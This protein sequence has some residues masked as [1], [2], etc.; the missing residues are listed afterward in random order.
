[1]KEKASSK[2]PFITHFPSDERNQRSMKISPVPSPANSVAAPTPQG[3]MVQKIRSLKMATNATPASSGPP[4]QEEV[5]EPGV[6]KL[7]I[8]ANN[9][10]TEA[11]TEATEP[12]SPQFAELARRRRA[13]QVKERELTDR[14]KALA[15]KSQG[16]DAVDLARLKSEPLSVLLEN[17][18]TYDQL[19]EAILAGQ[20][21]SEINAL[22]QEIIALKEGVDKKFVDRE[23]QAEQQ[24]LAEMRKEATLLTSSDDTFEMVR[25]TRSIPDVMKLIERTYRETGEVL[26]VKQACQMVEDYLFEEAHKL[27]SLKKVQNRL[28]PAEPPAPQVQ[29]RTGMRTLMN[30]DTASVPLSA[31]Q[32][33]L[34]AFYGNL[35]K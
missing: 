35:K 33:A 20:G 24:V 32:R 28:T 27:A 22:K 3:S 31:K 17:G 8:S 29:Q 15:S 12:L 21:N 4:V 13:L 7:P 6:E 34:A 11:K 23:T 25:E 9:E 30:K 1:M 14:E 16:S 10:T 5:S 19:T 18:V 2:R 26:D